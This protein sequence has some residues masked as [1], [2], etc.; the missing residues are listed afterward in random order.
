MKFEV[1]K[2]VVI[3]KS[4]KLDVTWTIEEPQLVRTLGLDTLK[5]NAELNLKRT[6]SGPLLIDQGW[7]EVYI[8]AKWRN[9]T[10]EWCRQNLKGQYS[11]MGTYWLFENKEDAAWFML[12]WS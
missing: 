7:T 1:E 2:T 5:E 12:R 9:I 8:G 3:T 4:R 6:V 10:D 11:C